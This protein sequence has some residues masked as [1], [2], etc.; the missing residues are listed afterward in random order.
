M[1]MSRTETL[2]KP[3]NGGVT[4]MPGRPSIA[5]VL[6]DSAE[7]IPRIRATLLRYLSFDDQQEVIAQP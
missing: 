7:E 1:Y 3:Q 2:D 5:N 6:D 4:E